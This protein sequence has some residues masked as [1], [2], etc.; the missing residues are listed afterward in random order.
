MLWS[1]VIS[2]PSRRT[3]RQFGAICVVGSAG[4]AGWQAWHGHADVR[5]A[6]LAGAALVVGV[7]GL[8]RPSSLRWIYTGLMVAT[9]PIAW[10]TSLLMLALTFYL[11]FTPVALLFRA[12]GRDPLGIRSRR[13]E[14]YW[15][16]KEGTENVDGY[17]R[18]S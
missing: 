1:E 11:V 18:Q 16:V 12:I 15:S 9:F 6:A 14:S 8:L 3:L 13:D 7:V 10:C 2:P 5:A 4:L 17:F